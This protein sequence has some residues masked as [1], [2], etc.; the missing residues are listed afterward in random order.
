MTEKSFYNAQFRHSEAEDLAALRQT[1]SAQPGLLDEIDLLR[2]A[3]RRTIELSSGIESLT[4]MVQVLKAL[5]TA[6]GQLAS[7]AR[8]YSQA[9]KKQDSSQGVLFSQAL[10]K[11]RQDMET[12]KLLPSSSAIPELREGQEEQP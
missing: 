2:V 12:E 8:A 6:A 10:D 11:I 7:L 1:D 9:R 4:E 5:A 3:M